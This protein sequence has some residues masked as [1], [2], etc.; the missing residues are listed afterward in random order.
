VSG[1]H[2]L[3][4]IARKLAFPQLGARIFLSRELEIGP[5]LRPWQGSP[6][7]RRLVR[8]RPRNP[9]GFSLSK[10]DMM[11]TESLRTGAASRFGLSQ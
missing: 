6:V 2:T 3:Q 4:M 9:I 11:L 7:A 8:A 10:V 5:G 1:V